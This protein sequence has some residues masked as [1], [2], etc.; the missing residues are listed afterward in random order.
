[1]FKSPTFPLILAVIF[2]VMSL[3]GCSSTEALP[4]T[5]CHKNIGIVF[6]IGGKNDR[7]FNAAGW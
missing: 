2:A 4:Q 5:G 6:D 3:S 1:M 7:L